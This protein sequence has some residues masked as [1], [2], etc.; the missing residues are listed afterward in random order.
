[1]VSGHDPHGPSGLV[2]AN[3]QSVR[4]R[5]ARA[6]EQA[7][8]P[9]QSVRLVLATKTVSPERI[10]EALD[11]GHRDLAENKVQEGRAK[12]VALAG[13]HLR[14]SM[15]GHLQTNK[16]K[17]ALRFVDEV[18]SLDRL[19]LAKALDRY[20]QRLGRSVDVLVQ[21]NTS[22]EATKYGLPPEDAVPFLREMRAFSCLRI[23]G[24]MTLA[25]FTP[26]VDEVRR[27][28]RRLRAVR[29]RA[30]QSAP[31]GAALQELSMGMSGDFE[32]AIAEG[33]TIVRLGQAVFGKRALP[34]EHFWPT[35][36]TSHG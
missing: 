14:W 16:V 20:L 8:R 3:L 6:A 33:A 36:S 25:R 30:R 22:N 12:A 35:T 13:R 23:C 24:F 10:L 4:N 11:A 2:A 18:Q 19:S 31:Q 5:I 28:F 32:V 26:D 17:D 27:C 9:A 34:D 29:D 7:G 15:I 21:V 1:M